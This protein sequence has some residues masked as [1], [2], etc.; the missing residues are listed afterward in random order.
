MKQADKLKW[1][2][3]FYMLL[4]SV[5]WQMVYQLSDTYYITHIES[6]KRCVVSDDSSLYGMS[7]LKSIDK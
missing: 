2:I 1:V 5:K 4:R 6:V 7:N 3:N